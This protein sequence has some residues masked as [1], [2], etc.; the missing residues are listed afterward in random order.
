MPDYNSKEQGE[1]SPEQACSLISHKWRKLLSSRRFLFSFV[2]AVL[3]FSGV[4]FVF[5]LFRFRLFVFLEAAAL[6]SILVQYAIAPT[7]TRN[8]L[9]TVCVLFCFCFVFRLF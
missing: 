4:T 9:T 3:S 8:Y 7:V 1:D 2:D 5:V 6:R